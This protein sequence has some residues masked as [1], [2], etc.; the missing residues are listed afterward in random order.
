MGNICRT[1]GRHAEKEEEGK[2]RRIVLLRK[3][4]FS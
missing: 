2:K 4:C 1:I 3:G